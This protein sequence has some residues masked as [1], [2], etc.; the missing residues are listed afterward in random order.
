MENLAN[1][2]VG[3]IVATNFRTSTVLTAHGIDFCCGGG[4]TLEE[5]CKNNNVSVETL[6]GELEESFKTRDKQ[7]YQNMPLDQLIQEIVNVHHKYVES[8]APALLAYLEK[9]GR[10]HGPRHPELLEIADLF[11][12]AAAALY[13]HMK[14]EEFVLFPYVQAMLDAKNNAFP[15]S[16]PHFEHIDNPIHMMEEEHE[17]EG[18]RFHAIAR[19]SNN[20]TCPPDGCQTYR[21]TYA[22]LQEF[23]DDLHKHIHLENNILF[24]RAQE[25]FSS[26]DFK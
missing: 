21:V 26:F 1:T 17:Q 22:L 24:P 4:I 15:L 25:L 23:E 5:A 3:K 8:T 13:T 12:G 10:V 14:K 9:L 18:E 6:I 7:D 11:G 16:R 2:K 20:Y 19:L